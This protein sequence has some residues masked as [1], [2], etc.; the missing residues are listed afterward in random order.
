[1]KR[2]PHCGAA[3]K[4]SAA[5][6]CPKCRKPLKKPGTNSGKSFQNAKPAGNPHPPQ[7]LQ[8]KTIPPQRRQTQTR[9]PKKKKEP[10][11]PAFLMPG[12]KQ[13]PVSEHVPSKKPMDENY[14]GYYEDRPTDDNAQ[15]KE[16]FDSELLKRIA[17]IAGGAVILVILSIILMNLL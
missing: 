17:F 12:K 6:F 16:S 7:T 11:L 4:A 15:N 2:C 5:A 3:I 13:P 14:D 1:M 8:Q 10:W 9:K